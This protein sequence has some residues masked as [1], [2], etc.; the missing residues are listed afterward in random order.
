[1]FDSQQLPSCL[2]AAKIAV[3]WNLGAAKDPKHPHG[4]YTRVRWDHEMIVKTIS[5]EYQVLHH[6]ARMVSLEGV[7]EKGNLSEY[8]LYVVRLFKAL[9]HLQVLLQLD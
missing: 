1:M 9:N 3:V 6:P 5:V 8:M 4:S 7:G 2:C